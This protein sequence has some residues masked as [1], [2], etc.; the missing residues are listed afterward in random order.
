MINDFLTLCIYVR[1]F[2]TGTLGKKSNY[3]LVLFLWANV[4]NLTVV[5]VPAVP[6]R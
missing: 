1:D 5:K 3:H 6:A 4:A 2:D